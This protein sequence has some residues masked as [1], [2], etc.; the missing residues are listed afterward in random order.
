M[1]IYLVGM[2]QS[3]DRLCNGGIRILGKKYLLCAPG[4]HRFADLLGTDQAVA[5]LQNRQIRRFESFDIFLRTHTEYYYKHFL[6]KVNK[7]SGNFPE[8]R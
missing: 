1:A 8:K 3:F 2:A 5:P 4:R 7:F 6:G